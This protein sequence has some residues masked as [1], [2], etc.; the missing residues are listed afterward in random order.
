MGIEVVHMLRAISDTKNRQKCPSDKPLRIPITKQLVC[1]LG[2]TTT[3][4]ISIS[5]QQISQL[6]SIVHMA[7]IIYRLLYY[8]VWKL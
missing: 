2:I 6:L 5:Y 8:K 1:A 4:R 7:L 3:K